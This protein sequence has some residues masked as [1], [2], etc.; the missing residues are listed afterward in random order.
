MKQSLI[1]DLDETLIYSISKKEKRTLSD[2]QLKNIKNFETVN[3]DD[4]YTVYA[5][6]GLQEFL[7]FAFSNFNVS[8]WT[9]ASKDYALFV[10]N[11]LILI[12]SKPDRHLDWTMFS[13][14]C[15][16]SK[17]KMKCIKDLQL[18]WNEYKL[19]GYTKSNTIIMDDHT[20]VYEKQPGNCIYMDPFDINLESIENDNFLMR[21]QP[22][23]E[24]LVTNNKPMNI[25]GINEM[26]KDQH[27][28]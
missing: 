27:G 6:P 17:K 7:D 2:T 5:R 14:H 13:Y 23:L 19:D 4:M 22:L 25:K 26:M 10:I 20:D 15:S 12:P 16:Q 1:L 9:A 18:I 3:M 21:L 24:Q 28:I 11:N 8:V